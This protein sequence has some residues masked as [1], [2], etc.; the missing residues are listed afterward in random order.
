MSAPTFV[1]FRNL[2]YEKS[3]IYF[4]DNKKYVLDSRLASRLAE[5][6]CTTFEEYL[7]LLKTDAWRDKELPALFN[8][9]TTNETFFFRDLP[10]L[11]AFNDLIL[12]AMIKENQGTKRLK[13][14]SAACSTGDEPFT[15]A[16]LLLER[17]REGAGSSGKEPALAGSGLAGAMTPG[18]GGCKG[19]KESVLAD[20]R[21]G[22]CNGDLGGWNVE[23][24]ASDI[25]EAAL[26]SARRGAYGPYAMRHVS[27]PLLSRYFTM[28]DG[29]H[30]VK[31]EVK[32]LV[33]FAHI[34]LF[35]S[36]RVKLMKGMDIIFCRNCLI[37]FDD[38]AKKRVVDSFYDCLNPRGYLLIGFSESLHNV[39]R[40]F[41]PI[42]SHKTVVYQKV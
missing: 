13:I 33:R 17:G 42:S 21:A 8:A 32:R 19:E 29:L 27:P 15:L 4:P 3:G 2:I 24:A 12:P 28:E 34:N 16:I 9:V 7:A 40:A 26:G 41:H 10:Q 37:Y 31:P 35:D 25:S 36:A 18:A 1:G 38:K 14:W 20:S 39:T 6:N 23:V 22:G 30:C 5:H 11:Q